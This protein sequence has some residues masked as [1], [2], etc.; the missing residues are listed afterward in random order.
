MA[1]VMVMVMV[2]VMVTVIVMVMV[3]ANVMVMAPSTPQQPEL[4]RHINQGLNMITP[5]GGPGRSVRRSLEHC[6]R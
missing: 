1:R 5:R 6:L 3:N 4:L 2:M